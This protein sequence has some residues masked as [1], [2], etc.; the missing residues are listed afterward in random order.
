MPNEPQKTMGEKQFNI[1]LETRNFEID[2]F[3]KR[4][5][6]FWGFIA[7]AFVGFATL[8]KNNIILSIIISCFGMVCS[9]A[10]TMGNRG[11]KY[12]QENW[13][14]KVSKYENEVVGDLFDKPEPI[15]NYKGPWLQARE[16]SVSKLVIALSDY[17]FLLWIF[18]VI[19]QLII[20]VLDYSYIN[21]LKNFAVIAFVILSSNYIILMLCK[22]K[23]SKRPLD[24]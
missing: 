9:F 23:T 8:Y 18:I 3:W 13:E 15:Q 22:C 5:V 2:L 21:K 17:V 10:W 19:T 1:S 4:S 16:Y 7:S 6:F 12:W 14:T 24:Q 20:V 11:S